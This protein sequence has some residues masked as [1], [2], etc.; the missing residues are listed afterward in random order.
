MNQLRLTQRHACM[1]YPENSDSIQ[2]MLNKADGYITYGPVS[3]DTVTTLLAN[4]GTVN[5][6]S[7]PEAVTDLGY[8]TVEEL[9]TAL[10]NGDTTLSDLTDHG[11]H[12]P[13]TLSPPSN[14]F[15]DTKK[16]VNQ[17]GSLGK[18]NTLDTLLSTMV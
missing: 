10:E 12:L 3:T 2:G 18:R 4:R 15:N 11:L 16:H 13:F 6:T 1:L 8:D 17:G 14:G 9:V 7:L 5:G